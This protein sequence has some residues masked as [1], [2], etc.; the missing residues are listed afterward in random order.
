MYY[1]PD[2]V[3]LTGKGET[4]FGIGNW[5]IPDS[6]EIERIIYFRINSSIQDSVLTENHWNDT[7]ASGKDVS[8]NGVNIFKDEAFNNINFLKDTAPQISSKG[9]ANGEILAYG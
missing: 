9:T 3:E 1:Q 8:G 4:Y 5:Y 2:D 7:K 6:R